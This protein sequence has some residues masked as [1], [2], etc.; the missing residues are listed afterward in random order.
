MQQP[1]ENT[2]VKHMWRISQ[3]GVRQTVFVNSKAEETLKGAS[4]RPVSHTMF[5]DLSDVPQMAHLVG[6][7]GNSRWDS[8]SH[9]RG[10]PDGSGR[11]I[12]SLHVDRSRYICI[13]KPPRRDWQA[14]GHIPP[15]SLAMGIT[16]PH[17]YEVITVLFWFTHS[18]S[19]HM[20][21]TQRVSDAAMVCGTLGG[22]WRQISTERG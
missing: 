7:P 21:I 14:G 13:K 10:I 5:H 11:Q 15:K 12:L 3:N 8:Q 18:L 9:H 1:G 22:L 17:G 2:I 4:T 20:C 16:D 6:G 19:F